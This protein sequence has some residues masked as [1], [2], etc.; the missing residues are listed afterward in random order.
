[1]KSGSEMEEGDA[2]TDRVMQPGTS[3][4]NCVIKTFCGRQNNNTLT[5]LAGRDVFTLLSTY[6]LITQT[7]NT[8]TIEVK[9]NCQEL[10][11]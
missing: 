4:S 7:P 9:E 6:S 2:G 5:P 11:L 1:M 8:S 3:G 10:G